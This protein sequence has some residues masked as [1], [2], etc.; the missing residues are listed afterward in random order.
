MVLSSSDILSPRKRSRG[1]A[2]G[3][4]TKVGAALHPV[5]GLR[6]LGSGILEG[7]NLADPGTAIFVCRSET[8]GQ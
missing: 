3:I 4:R 6:P 5:A 7:P 1:T 8:G 2:A